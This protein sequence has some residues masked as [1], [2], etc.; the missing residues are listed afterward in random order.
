MFEPR[1]EFEE[2]REDFGDFEELQQNEKAAILR[3]MLIEVVSQAGKAYQLNKKKAL[4]VE[5]EV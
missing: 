1:F 2:A 5:K 4:A 3:R